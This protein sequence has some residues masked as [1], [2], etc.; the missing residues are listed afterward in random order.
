MNKRTLLFSLSGGYFLYGF[1]QYFAFF[2]FPAILRANDVGNDVIGATMMLFL[3]FVMTFIYAPSL[4]RFQHKKGQN[5]EKRLILLC[6]V[7]VAICYASLGGFAPQ[8]QPFAMMSVLLLA[9]FFLASAEIIYNGVI[10]D[11]IN[12]EGLVENGALRLI[13]NYIAGIIATSGMLWLLQILGQTGYLLM[14]ACLLLLALSIVWLPPVLNH[15]DG[16]DSPSILK[17]FKNKN[18]RQGL[19]FSLVISLTLRLPFSQLSPLMIDSGFEIEDVAFW[20]GVGSCILGMVGSIVA[21]WA[22]KHFP[23]PKVM[24]LVFVFYVFGFLGFLANIFYFQ[25]IL[26]LGIIFSI[27][28]AVMSVLYVGIFSVWMHWCSGE[29]SAS[30]YA[31]LKSCDYFILI[32]SSFVSGFIVEIGREIH[33][34]GNA[35]GGYASLFML[36]LCL[37]LLALWLIIPRLLKNI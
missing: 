34:F 7:M 37:L 13:L 33:L 27:T 3:P 14:G 10:I 30:N 9:M 28:M 16:D 23:T 29:G 18:V 21:V 31:L 19:V 20:G 25:S 11:N 6:G 24:L 32:L 17:S 22:Y 12:K 15:K 2:S 4:E 35:L 36:S 1:L 26:M 5:R 8:S